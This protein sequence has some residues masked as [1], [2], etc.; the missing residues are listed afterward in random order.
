MHPGSIHTFFM[1]II[2]SK[3]KSTAMGRVLLKTFSHD[4]VYYESRKYGRVFKDE[5]RHSAYP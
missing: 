4:I 2:P 5:K 3:P 1:R